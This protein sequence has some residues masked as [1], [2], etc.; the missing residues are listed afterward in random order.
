MYYVKNELILLNYID[1]RHHVTAHW[2]QAIPHQSRHDVKLRPSWLD[3]F[4]NSESYWKSASNWPEPAAIYTG[5]I[6]PNIWK[7]MF[8]TTN[9]YTMLVS[10]II[11]KSSFTRSDRHQTLMQTAATWLNVGIWPEKLADNVHL[12][13]G[14]HHFWGR[15]FYIFPP[16]SQVA[17]GQRIGVGAIILQ[18][19]RWE[20]QRNTR[21]QLLWQ[22]SANYDNA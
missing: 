22:I 17:V 11:D 14:Q 8:Q 19:V 2:V 20:P 18:L 10:C 7:K 4:I 1:M 6:I 9:Q 15:V 3:G 5:M 21:Q 12:P 13:T 16:Q